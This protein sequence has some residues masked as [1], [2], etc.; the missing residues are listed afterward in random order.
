M[1]RRPDPSGD[2]AKQPRADATRVGSRQRVDL[3]LTQSVVSG[4]V[5]DNAGLPLQGAVVQ[6]GE[7]HTLT[8]SDGL[9]TLK[10]ATPGAE[11]TITAP[12]YKSFTGTVD[13]EPL[14]H[15]ELEPQVTGGVYAGWSFSARSIRFAPDDAALGRSFLCE[16]GGV[17]TG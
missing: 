16:C 8:D 2:R 11:I 1:E 4:T 13:G 3:L 15:I 17:V 10:G 14:D 7:L 5:F 6:S 9:F 12:G